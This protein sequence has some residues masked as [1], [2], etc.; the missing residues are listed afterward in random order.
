MNTIIVAI[1][2]I[3]AILTTGGIVYA[4]SNIIN[5]S[6]SEVIVTNSTVILGNGNTV[7]SSTPTPPQTQ[8][9]TNENPTGVIFSSPSQAPMPTP[10]YQTVTFTWYLKP[11]YLNNVTWLNQTWGTH[12][13]L[14][15]TSPKAPYYNETSSWKENYLNFLAS[16]HYYVVRLHPS[17][18]DYVSAN[19]DMETGYTV[20]VNK[21]IN[22]IYLDPYYSHNYAILNLLEP[23]LKYIGHSEIKWQLNHVVICDERGYTVTFN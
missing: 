16:I 18:D 7:I 20:L 9:P 17:L 22:Y 8:T 23:T 11:Q 3:V 4:Y 19:V 1:L 15:L 10:I 12:T 5:I 14:N 2:F 21:F 13:T 6:N